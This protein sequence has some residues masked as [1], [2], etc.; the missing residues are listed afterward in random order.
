MHLN[1]LYIGRVLRKRNPVFYT[2]QCNYFAS[3][4]HD[5]AVCWNWSSNW[6]TWVIHINDYHLSLLSYFLSN[7]DEFV[8]LHSQGTK[9]NVCWVYTQVLELEEKQT[10]IKNHVTKWIRQ[11][12]YNCIIV[13]TN[14]HLTSNALRS[15]VKIHYIDLSEAIDSQMM[16]QTSVLPTNMAFDC[17]AITF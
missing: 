3:W 8:W 6:I 12:W 9:A 16:N 17:F 5:G 13:T 11:I 7:A 10:N 2:F 4:I 14:P 1:K 15:T